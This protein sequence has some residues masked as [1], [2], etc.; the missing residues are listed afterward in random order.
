MPP[1]LRRIPKRLLDC[2]D[3][4]QQA[5]AN[6]RAIILDLAKRKEANIGVIYAQL[7]LIVAETETSDTA[8]ERLEFETREEIKSTEPVREIEHDHAA[9]D[10][11]V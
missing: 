5:N 4:G 6:I 3:A 7:H 2:Q 1:S 9:E 10:Y 8:W 11:P